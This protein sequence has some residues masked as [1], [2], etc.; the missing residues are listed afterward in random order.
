MAWSDLL[1]ELLHL[2]TASF[3]LTREE[4]LR[5][6]SLFQWPEIGISPAAPS[7]GGAEA[8][9]LCRVWW[10]RR[11][12]RRRTFGPTHHTQTWSH[13]GCA[14]LQD[15][16]VSEDGVRPTDV[17]ERRKEAERQERQMR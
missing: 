12:L 6:V 9:G 16:R 15:S 14:S 10:M 2:Q 5:T 3:L 4:H 11:K 1:P 7:P 8:A 13:C 17:D